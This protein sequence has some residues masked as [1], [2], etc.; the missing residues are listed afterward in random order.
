MKKFRLMLWMQLLMLPLI[1]FSSFSGCEKEED[2]IIIDT[3][4]LNDSI[5]ASTLFEYYQIP[6]NELNG[7]DEGFYYANESG[8]ICPYYIVSSTD[9]V[10]G[11][12]IVC[13]NE[14]SNT[15]AE[16]SLIF[17]FSKEGEVLKV[18]LSEYH[19]EAQSEDDKVNFVVYDTEGNAMGGFSVPYV[20]IETR[21]NTR[22]PFFNSKGEL[23]VSKTLNFADFMEKGA[24]VLG[25]AWNLSEGNYGEVVADFLLGRM[26]GT[27][28]SIFA[29]IF[30]PL[31]VKNILEWFYEEAK[32]SWMGDAGIRITSA[33]RTSETTITVE[34]EIT[35]IYSI[36]LIYMDVTDDGIADWK[37]NV[38]R[39]GVAVGRNSY[40]GLYLNENC[41]ELEVVSQEENFSFTF[42]MDET[43][44]EIFYFRPFLVPESK[45]KGKDDLFPTPNTC[46]RYGEA[47]RFVDM[48]VE[49]S[50]FKQVKCEKHGDEYNVQFTID[51]KIPELFDDLAGWGIKV[52]AKS[53]F[54]DWG[55]YYATKENPES[56]FAPTE[57]T[58][59][60][61]I[62]ITED[63]IT[64]YGIERIAEVIITPFISYRSSILNDYF[65]DE[66]YTLTISGESCS[67]AN[68]VH[69]VDLGLSVKWACC[70]VGASVPEGYGG[71]YAWGETE[72]KS[73]YTEE[74]YQYARDLDGDG[75]YWDDED[76]WINIGSNISGTQYDAAHVK[77]G[78]SW[79]MPTRDEIKELVN[80]CSW[81]WTSLNGVN[82]QLVT[83]PNGNSIFLP[84]AG[85]RN[86]T[87]LGRRGSYGYYWSATLDEDGSGDAYNLDFN[88]GDSGW[89][90]WLGRGGGFTVR[91]VTE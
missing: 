84:A 68:H 91:P 77:W 90:D 23:S 30:V 35:D 59:T 71:Y 26:T 41:S 85:Y 27:V 52:S 64:D 48:T 87:G 8:T 45:L 21:P 9:S 29:R 72:E 40:P 19:F 36:P 82:G 89:G 2:E 51:G 6:T 42:Y 7:W 53:K 50:N 17:H 76:N 78:G 31:T 20:K 55:L 39:Y 66:S 61:D 70:N 5:L 18:L 28:K 88:N 24:N 13:L 56:Y 80:K 32:K 34:G 46:I 47:K 75:N 44:G 38:V 4:E 33:K 63:D 22:S 25:N 49:L 37:D 15:N 16:N 69:A 62:K 10:N 3:P 83:G 74:T 54:K 79:R 60:C 43:P 58:F 1:V 12:I 81:K 14:T 86:G 11:D 65:E 73:N 57:N 67:D